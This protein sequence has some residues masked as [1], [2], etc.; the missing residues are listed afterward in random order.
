M[1]LGESHEI[2]EGDEVRR[3]GEVLSIGVGD[4]F[5]GRVVDPLGRPIDGKGDIEHEATRV[6]ELQAPSV[7]Q[8]QPVTEPLQTGIKAV[9]A[10]TNVGR[11]QR[12]LIIGDRQTG[13]TAV[14]VD[15]IIA[16][17]DNWKTGDPA[18]QVK[19]IY[20][21]VGQKGSTIAALVARL[22]EAGGARI[23]D[24]R[25]RPGR[26]APPASNTSPRTPAPRSGSTGCTRVSTR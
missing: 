14:A 21:A 3:S 12:Q 24:H 2:G 10:M 19:C 6:L 26:D 15:A 23:H 11:G 17:R 25:R 18:K 22:E 20:V 1:L 9:D 4:G 8:R 7:V 5:L 16:Q 13:K